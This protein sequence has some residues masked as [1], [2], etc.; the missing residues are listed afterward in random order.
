MLGEKG[1][2]AAFVQFSDFAAICLKVCVCLTKPGEQMEQSMLQMPEGDG[3]QQSGCQMFAPRHTM[4]AV[5]R[6]RHKLKNQEM[7]A[8]GQRQLQIPLTVKLHPHVQRTHCLRR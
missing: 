8:M 5:D 2:S 7:G 6:I 3:Q 4:G 1:K